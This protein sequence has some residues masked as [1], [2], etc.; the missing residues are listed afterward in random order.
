MFLWIACIAI[1]L[2]ITNVEGSLGNVKRSNQENMSCTKENAIINV[3]PIR[4]DERLSNVQI[5]FCK[6]GKSNYKTLALSQEKCF[7]SSAKTNETHPISIYCFPELEPSQNYR[8]SKP[9]DS[10]ITE[11]AIQFDYCGNNCNDEEFAFK[12]Y[13]CLLIK[14]GDFGYYKAHYWKPTSTNNLVKIN[15]TEASQMTS[16][17]VSRKIQ[18]TKTKAV[19]LTFFLPELYIVTPLP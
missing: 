2:P 13:R 8:I 11:M 6:N 19:S 9:R 10:F 14:F 4:S 7:L 1:L 12:S 16:D 5:E 18:N 3:V 15:E 17:V